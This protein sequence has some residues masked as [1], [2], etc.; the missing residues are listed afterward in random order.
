MELKL[1]RTAV[2][3]FTASAAFF[4]ASCAWHRPSHRAKFTALAVGSTQRA[5]IKS[6][7][8]SAHFRCCDA[9]SAYFEEPAQQ[10][11]H[12]SLRVYVV[13]HAATDEVGSIC[14]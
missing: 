4:S 8:A 5:L 13:M 10:N 12:T 1:N 14:S 11:W 9:F 6:S 3:D 7:S 2:Q